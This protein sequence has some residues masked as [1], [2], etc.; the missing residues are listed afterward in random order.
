MA[1]PYI[2][3]EGILGTGKSSQA[4]KLYK[5]LSQIYADNKLV[6]TREPGGSEIAEHIRDNVL[7]P[8]FSEKMEIVAEAY[9]FAASRA[10]TL[11]TIV[12][13]AL[14]A[15]QIVVCDRSIISSLANQGY[16]RGLGIDEVLDINRRAVGSTYPG[17]I[18]YIKIPFEVGWSRRHDLNSDK[19]D[20]L[21][22]AF[23][24][25]VL[26]G[27][28]EIS[29]MDGIFDRWETIDGTQSIDAVFEDVKT[30]AIKYLQDIGYK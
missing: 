2:V 29:K 20:S 7:K 18:I 9:L 1:G 24:E 28:G 12:R 11:R 21:D 5:Y 13:P 17:L 14:K 22:K 16:G 4:Q 8:H 15:G 30:K 23:Y 26:H 10:Q 27:Y 3:F 6:L 25:K 19:F